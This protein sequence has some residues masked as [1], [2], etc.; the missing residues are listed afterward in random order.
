MTKFTDLNLNPKVLKAIEEAGYESP[1][2]IQAGAIPPALQGRDVLGIAQ[3]GTGK[4]ASFTLPM[5]T[6]L[7]RGRARARMPRSLVLCPT[8]EL[9]AQVAENF[10]TYT[11]HLKLTKALLIGGVSFKEQDALIDK[12]VDVL[13]ATPGRL[14]DHFERGKLLLTGVQIMVV[15][16]ADRMLDMGFI[17]DIERIF[18]L[19]PF[20]RQTLFFSATMAPEIERITNTFLSNP[21]RIE[22]ARQATASETIEQAVVE[23]K[24]SRRDREGSEKRHL[25]RALIDGEGDKLSNGIIFCNRKTDVD[26]VAKSLKKYGYDAAPIHGDLDQSQRT[27]TLDGFRDGSLRI[28][29]ASDVAARGLDVP[30]VSHVFNFD[31]PSHAEDYV[32]RI[33]RTGRAGRE[34]KAIT[35]SSTR[36]EKLL[37]AVERLL[38]KQIPRLENPL[39]SAPV[40]E[41]AE[42]PEA[43]APQSDDSRSSERSRSKPASKPAPKASGSSSSSSSH[44]S[45]A[46]KSSKSRSSSS[47]GQDSKV[48]GMGNHMPS[49]IALS[50]EERRATA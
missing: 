46:P 50:F 35:I 4:T 44:K 9:A 42:A 16:E 41:V 1:T 11:K 12:G 29:V 6:L 17:P 38:Q 28:L 8:R 27:R 37:D 10:D 40:A 13:I 30:S 47:R 19:T 24:A 7:A 48:V 2:P 34:G 18:S 14:L 15:D 25:L 26:I 21:E 32:H 43:D 36:D 23:F 33:G 3:T 31:V 22:I 39:K 5:I 45:G 20:T 49:F